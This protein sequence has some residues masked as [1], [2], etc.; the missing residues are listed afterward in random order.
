MLSKHLGMDS[1]RALNVACGIWHQDVSNRS[2]KTCELHGDVS[3]DL[4]HPTDALCDK[5][6]GIL[7]STL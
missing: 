2:F 5:I 1:T 3:M 4:A 7:E 6:W